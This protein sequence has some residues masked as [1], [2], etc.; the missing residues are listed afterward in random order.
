MAELAR[1]RICGPITGAD[2]DRL[3]LFVSDDTAEA[4]M[5]AQ[6]G[7]RGALATPGRDDRAI[8]PPGCGCLTVGRRRVCR[9]RRCGRPEAAPRLPR[10]A[11]SAFPGSTRRPA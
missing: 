6:A 1:G 5:M 4:S 8:R 7:L 3:L 11:A 10:A 9:P 2:S